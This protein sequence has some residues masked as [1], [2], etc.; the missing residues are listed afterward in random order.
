MNV[1]QSFSPKDT[2]LQRYMGYVYPLL[3]LLVSYLEVSC[4]RMTQR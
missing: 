4:Q 3:D 2:H 1:E